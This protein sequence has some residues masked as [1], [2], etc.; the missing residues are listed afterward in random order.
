MRKLEKNFIRVGNFSIL[1]CFLN[2]FD[3]NSFLE[4]I[5]QFLDRFEQ[6]S[7]F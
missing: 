6:F 1:P 5:K 2:N 3:F 4:N 7:Q